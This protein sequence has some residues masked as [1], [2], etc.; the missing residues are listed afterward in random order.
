VANA[1]TSAAAAV[2]DP[3]AESIAPCRAFLLR[4]RA[5]AHAAIPAASGPIR[6][7]EFAMAPVVEAQSVSVSSVLAAYTIPAANS[8]GATRIPG[9]RRS[10]IKYPLIDLSLRL[11]AESHSGIRVRGLNRQPRLWL[12]QRAF[13]QYR[14]TLCHLR[15]AS[16]AGRQRVGHL[17]QRG[18]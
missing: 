14:Q 13:P 6:K 18:C 4:P 12:L 1:P 15:E 16:A 2:T 5:P 11:V 3:R 8:N 10:S 17:Q 9:P 7:G